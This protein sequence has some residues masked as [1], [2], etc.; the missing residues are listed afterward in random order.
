M[1]R[2]KEELTLADICLD[3][4]AEQQTQLARIVDE[5]GQWLLAWHRLAFLGNAAGGPAKTAQVALQ[6]ARD[7]PLPKT[8]SAWFRGPAQRLPAEQP[9]IDRLAV[10]HDQ[11]HKFAKMMLLKAEGAPLPPLDYELVMTRYTDFMA[12]LRRFERGF[13]AA[14]AG[15]DLLTGLRSRFTL[16]ADLAAEQKRMARAGQPLALALG[17]IDKFREINALHGTETGDR[18]LTQL[19]EAIQGVIRT[20]D[21]GYRVEADAFL[22]VLKGAKGEDARNVIERLRA[23][24]E[25]TKLRLFGGGTT[26]VTASFGVVEATADEPLPELLRRLEGALDSVRAD[27]GNKVVFA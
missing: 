16:A 27:G 18:A 15:Q 25:E 19:G 23:R 24:V 8:F 21:D 7:L 1:P 13:A 14:A 12:A 20:Y 6:A 3:S 9:Q 2:A 26:T 5:H 11:L 10:L 17:D 4:G 22:I